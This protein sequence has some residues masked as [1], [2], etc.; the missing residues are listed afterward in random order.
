VRK[1]DL[2]FAERLRDLIS[3]RGYLTDEAKIAAAK[4]AYGGMTSD[5]AFLKKAESKLAI[6]EI[7]AVVKG[8]DSTP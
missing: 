7:A 5:E 3:E 6:P 4:G 1:R 8:T 2:A